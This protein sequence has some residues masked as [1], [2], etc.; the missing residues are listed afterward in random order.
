MEGSGHGSAKPDLDYFLTLKWKPAHHKNIRAEWIMGNIDYSQLVAS[1]AAT[2][3][4]V[5]KAS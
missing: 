1:P 4:C 2:L 3:V 5:S